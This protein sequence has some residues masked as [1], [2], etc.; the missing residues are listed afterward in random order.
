MFQMKLDAQRQNY[1][2][3]MSAISDSFN[4]LTSDVNKLFDLVEKIAEP[5]FEYFTDFKMHDALNKL[6]EKYRRFWES[7]DS[8]R[9]VHKQNGHWGQ[10]RETILE[11]LHPLAMDYTTHAGKLASNAPNVAVFSSTWPVVETAMEQNV[12]HLNF[13]YDEFSEID[14]DPN[15]L[16]N[17]KEIAE[18][19]YFAMSSL[20]D[21]LIQQWTPFG[22]YEDKG[23]AA[24][25]ETQLSIFKKASIDIEKYANHARSL[26]RKLW[27]IKKQVELS[28]QA[29]AGH[30]AENAVSRM[31]KLASLLAKGLITQDEYDQ[32]KAKLL[33]EI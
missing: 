9:E 10:F 23:W 27:E 16:H 4:Q 33:E 26:F 20:G 25:F 21:I 6:D 17:L 14:F 3:Q 5:E 11:T 15:V 29:S 8:A 24:E 2:A 19:S 31:E 32:K 13:D 22:D 28:Q 12:E 1:E 30:E 7:A 18:K